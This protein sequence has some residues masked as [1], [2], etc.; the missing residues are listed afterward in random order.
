MGGIWC[1]LV[2]MEIAYTDYMLIKFAVLL[3]LAFLAGLFGFLD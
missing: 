1:Y 2:G 3:A